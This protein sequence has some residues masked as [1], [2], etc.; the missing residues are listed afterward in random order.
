MTATNRRRGPRDP[1]LLMALS[2]AGLLGI[3]AAVT[4]FGPVVLLAVPAGAL[5]LWGTSELLRARRGVHARFDRAARHLARPRHLRHVTSRGAAEAAARLGARTRV[6][7]VYVGRSVRGDQDLWGTWEDMHLDIWGPRTGKTTTR[8]IPSVVAAPGCAIVASNKRDIVDATR[9]VRER[10]G[11]I[12]VFDPQNQAGEQ[13]GWWWNP[14]SFIGGN[15]RSALTLASFMAGINQQSHQRSDDFFEPAGMD[16]FGYLLLAADLDDRP[17]TDVYVWLTRPSD[18]TPATILR[19]GGQRYAAATVQMV[20]S[21]PAKQRAG[22]Y[23]AALQMASFLIAPGITEW[24][25]PPEEGDPRP[26]FRHDDFVQSDCETLYMLSEETN[27]MAAP[28]VIALT[29]AVAYAAEGRS[30]DYPGGR[31]PIPALFVLDE[32]ANICPLEELTFFYAHYGARGIVMMTFLQSWAQGVAVWGETGMAQLWGSANVRVYGG[33]V[34]DTRF[35]RDL[36]ESTGRFEPRTHEVGR[37]PW[38][39]TNPSLSFAS[40]SEYVL[41]E[42]DLAALPRGRAFVQFSGA[43]PTLVKPVPWWRGPYADE[44]RASLER[45]GPKPAGADDSG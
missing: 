7:G 3:F 33:G 32:A 24:I 16:L 29:T 42:A 21:S 45:Y 44:I 6:P 18:T 43:P 25:T 4:R 26:E 17:I 8:A 31:L 9:G 11:R 15:V 5:L 2:V 20:I 37:S 23:G 10:R 19:R 34:S 40:R 22:V 41:D 1:N 38:W 39:T 12:W 28:V 13:A 14:L 27:K 35:L 36:S 30:G